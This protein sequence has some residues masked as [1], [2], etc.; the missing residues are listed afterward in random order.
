MRCRPVSRVGPPN[1]FVRSQDLPLSS[2]RLGYATSA[3]LPRGGLPI[4]EDFQ[5]PPAVVN[6]AATSRRDC[7]QVAELGADGARRPREQGYAQAVVTLLAAGLIAGLATFLSPCVL[8]MVPVVFASGTAGGR[9]R[10]VGIAIGLA[11]TFVLAT[12]LASRLLDALG[13][14]QDL[15]RNLGIAVLAL[16]GLAL[17]FPAF[18]ELAGRPFRPLQRA[19]GNRLGNADGFLGGLAIGA[20]LGVVWA[21]CAGPI[22]GAV[23]VLAAQHRVGGQALLLAVAYAVGAALPLLGVALLGRRA[24][25][26]LR[27]P[28][29]APPPPPPGPGA[30]LGGAGGALPPPRSRP[31]A[32]PPPPPT[33]PRARG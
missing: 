27:G 4:G 7:E 28:P 23:S 2:R 20:G 8:P 18:G 32:P 1:G 30:P 10:P 33:P 12:L 17:V 11:V 24:T 3:S 21:P 31:P 5:P 14:P 16:V 19:A 26:R 29:P 6:A 13:L 25:G 15:V 9:R 22:L